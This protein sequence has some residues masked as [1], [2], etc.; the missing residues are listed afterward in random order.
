M[1]SEDE[2][3]KVVPDITRDKVNPQ[4]P[5]FSTAIAT[6]GQSQEQKLQDTSTKV[7]TI[8]K[9]V[10]IKQQTKIVEETTKEQAG[11]IDAPVPTAQTQG[12]LQIIVIDQD[13]LEEDM[14]IPKGKEEETIQTL[15]NLLTTGTPTIVL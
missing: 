3:Q 14:D 10:M 6:C 7:D 12:A 1:V 2:L 9:V 4:E 5:P 15:V 11:Q 13:K 8:V